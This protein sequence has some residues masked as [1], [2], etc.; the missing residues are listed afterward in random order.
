MPMAPRGGVVGL[1]LA[2]EF[3]TGADAATLTTRALERGLILL[4]SAE[5]GDVVSITPPLCISEEA[6]NHAIGILVEIVS[7]IEQAGAS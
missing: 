1:L 5:G 4:Q 6:L 2:I 3:N 7:E